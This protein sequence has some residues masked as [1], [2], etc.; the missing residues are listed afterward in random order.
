MCD[1]PLT[2]GGTE[3]VIYRGHTLRAKPPS[4][5]TPIRAA[6]ARYGLAHNT[7]WKLIGSGEVKAGLQPHE[8]RG[9]VSHAGRRWRV[10]VSRA[11]LK[12]VTATKNARLTEKV[13]H[14]PPPDGVPVDQLARE[15][16][17]DGSV[18]RNW[19]AMETHPALGRRIRSGIG[20]YTFT[21]GNRQIRWRG[22]LASRADVTEC[23][24]AVKDPLH[25]RLPGNPGVWIEDGIFLHDTDGVFFTE[26]YIRGQERYGLRGVALYQSRHI[27]P[28]RVTFPGRE[29]WGRLVFSSAALDRLV[30]RRRGKADGGEWLIPG[31]IWQDGEGLWYSSRLIARRLGRKIG[32][33]HRLLRG[34]WPSV[35]VRY[36]EVPPPAGAHKGGPPMVHHE[37]DIRQL[38]GIASPTN[39][40]SP[41]QPAT[42]PQPRKKVGRPKGKRSEDVVRREREMLEKWDQGAYGDNMA[43]A[44]KAHG[45][46]DRS[47]ARRII[48][49]HEK[50]KRRK[51]S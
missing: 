12:R 46:N 1:T 24:Q 35:S 6:A 14:S 43:A 41:A 18:I 44:G 19:C 11:G 34:K 32:E 39:V 21:S 23:V 7:I 29:K 30:E 17:F 8:G 27:K 20:P 37:R 9:G 49:A 22:L 26:K 15:L 40:S 36:K 4:D 51:E 48:K 47:A 10:L 45:F 5:G 16:E 33:M 3:F 28:L 50:E 13:S 31:D 2:E 38:L 42:P 25:R